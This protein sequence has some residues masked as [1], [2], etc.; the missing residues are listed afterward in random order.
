MLICACPSGMS[1]SAFIMLC[2]ASLIY[3]GW[4]L[5]TSLTS[6]AGFAE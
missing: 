3:Y 5:E 2:N 4:L 6:L 1:F